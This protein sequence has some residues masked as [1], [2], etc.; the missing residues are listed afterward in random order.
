MDTEASPPKRVTRAR[1][2]KASVSSAT[3]GTAASAAKAKATAT[4]AT[5]KAKAARPATSTTADSAPAV[6]KSTKRKE[7]EDDQDNES[8]VEALQNRPPPGSRT[9]TRATRGAGRPKKAGNSNAAPVPVPA[10]A[11]RAT[12]GRPPKK[13]ATEAIKKEAPTSAPRTRAKQTHAGEE[14][15]EDDG[16]DD[17]APEP[18]KRPRGRPAGTATSA[19]ALVSKPKK[20][21]TFAEP[22]KENVVPVAGAKNRATT[23]TTKPVEIQ[24]STGMRAKPV[25]KPAGTSRTARTTATKKSAKDSQDKKKG[26]MPLSPKKVSQVSA[27]RDRDADSEDELAMDG[28]PAR[29]FNRGPVKPAGAIRHTVKAQDQVSIDEQ[30]KLA[31][32]PT[33]SAMLLNSPARRPPPTTLESSMVS[34]AKRVDGLQLS[35]SA[36]GDNAKPSASSFK[37]SLLQSPAKRMPVKSVDL[38]HFSSSREQ[39]IHAAQSNT[40]P[41]KA[42][43]LQTPAKRMPMKPADLDPF[44]S[45]Y[46]QNNVSPFKQSLFQSPAKRAFSPIKPSKAS[47]PEEITD[48]RSPAPT[49]V[50]L[51][52]PP[53]AEDIKDDVPARPVDADG[54]GATD[55]EENAGPS[56]RSD[57]NGRMSTLLPREVDPALDHATSPVFE[58]AEDDDGETVVFEERSEVQVEI[59]EDPGILMDVDI[60]APGHQ[61]E[62]VTI[63]DISTTPPNSPPK[64]ALTMFGLRDKDLIPFDTTYSESDDDDDTTR[65]MT[66]IAASPVKQMRGSVM[67]PR[68]S[69]LGFT[70]LAQRFDEWQPQS[71]HQPKTPRVEKAVGVDKN[72]P[73]TKNSPVKDTFFDDEMSSRPEQ[74]NDR[75]NEFDPQAGVPEIKEPVI[76]DISITDEDLDLAAEANEMSVLSP[77]QVESMLNLDGNDD[78]V[79]EASQEYGDENEVP[80]QILNG[81]SVP[82]VTPQRRIRREFHTVSKVPL[83][84]ADESTPPPQP[85]LRKRRH[86]ISRLPTSRPTH[87]MSRSA[88]VISYSPT[89]TKQDD[90]AFEEAAAEESFH[91][92]SRSL[93]PPETPSRP[94][95]WSEA[96]TPGCSPRRNVN[97]SLLSGAVIF[98]DVHTV[99]GADAS[100]IF[101]ELL[102]QMGARCLKTWQWNPSAEHSKIGITHV[103]FKDGGKPT[104]EKVREAGGAVHCVGVSWVLD[105]ER[106][107]QWL[108]EAPYYIDSALIPRGGA[109]RRKSMEP[110]SLANMNVTLVSSSATRNTKRESQVAPTTPAPANRRDSGLWMHSPDD[111]D[112]LGDDFDLEGLDFDIPAD[113]EDWYN[114]APLT[115]VPKT[116]APEAIHRFAMEVDLDSPITEA[117]DDEDV[118]V[119]EMMSREHLIQQTCP[120]KA[121]HMYQ[122]LGAG[123]LG[124]DRDQNVA[125]RLMDARRKSLAFAP[126]I[127]SP[128]ARS[129]WKDWN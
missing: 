12:R 46:E 108:D 20:T 88:T 57:F 6:R 73:E 60:D 8:E 97:P 82:P 32:P 76:E 112:N 101:V 104:M 17:L 96:E 123:I 14:E 118:G 84:A 79:S 37:A 103:L 49:P 99:E 9:A 35:V 18:V 34:P 1:A 129:S 128:L 95:T 30:D 110:K 19:S 2:A 114:T 50:L 107:N 47:E 92:R 61:S 83:K 106:E 113:Q 7:R 126:K 11:P 27:S 21:V 48:T 54:G 29:L 70:P 124:L 91:E 58:S 24:A 93:S 43:L 69:G 105:C 33:D 78:T 89:H 51:C 28:T 63:G 109:R 13:V 42:S 80:N 111:S 4:A 115:P 86:S 53:A 121:Q 56:A 3:S 62:H 68:T 85:S 16:A 81:V 23:T 26:S 65:I 90:T 102:T 77:E 40:S 125:R 94:E 87:Q 59:F 45:S 25:R 64:E 31:L 72:A 41:L 120:P 15:E 36:F 5:N 66:P 127:S 122:D 117:D 74:A 98:V 10:P 22:D 38:D 55:E 67:R 119:D 116:P 71:S 44:T 100:A 39:T 52:S 75:A